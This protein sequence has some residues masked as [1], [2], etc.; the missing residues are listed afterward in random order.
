MGVLRLIQRHIKQILARKEAGGGPPLDK[1]RLLRASES[2]SGSV[3]T[4]KEPPRCLADK[5]VKVA[6]LWQSGRSAESR[7]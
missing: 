6:I 7:V 4:G 2:H 3:V 5:V 1:D